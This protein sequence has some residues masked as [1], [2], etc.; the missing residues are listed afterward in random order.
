M[1]SLNYITWSR[2][3]ENEIFP[4]FYGFT[5]D[6]FENMMSD[7]TIPKEAFDQKEK[8]LKWYN[9]HKAF[10]FEILNTYSIVKF[11]ENKKFIYTRSLYQRMVWIEAFFKKNYWENKG[12][13][14]C[15]VKQYLSMYKIR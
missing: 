3:L 10:N 7:N 2:F 8:A 5:K 13:T 4:E 14:C 11:V 6:K 12:K 1:S 9:G 15:T